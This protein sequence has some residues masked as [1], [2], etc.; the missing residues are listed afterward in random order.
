MRLSLF[1]LATLCTLILGAQRTYINTVDNAVFGSLGIVLPAGPSGHVLFSL[2]QGYLVRYDFCGNQLFAREIDLPGNPELVDLIALSNGDFGLLAA[3]ANIRRDAIVARLDSS[4]NLLWINQYQDANFDQRQFPYSLV[5]ISANRLSYYANLESLS[6]NDTQNLLLWLDAQGA[7]VQARTYSLGR[8]WGRCIAT[9]DSGLLFRTGNRLVKVNE[10]GFVQWAREYLVPNTSSDFSR[11]IALQDGYV[12]FNRLNGSD[13]LVGNKVNLTGQLTHSVRYDAQGGVG[14]PAAI[15]TGSVGLAFTQDFGTGQSSATLVRFGGDSLQIER[16]LSLDGL[17]GIGRS[18]CV[19]NNGKLA[20]AGA[21]TDFP[22]KSFSGITDMDLN[23]GCRRITQG[24]NSTAYAVTDNALA[25]SVAPATFNAVPYIANVLNPSLTIQSQCIPAAV[26][27]L[28]QDTA[29]CA[30]DSL[31]LANVNGYFEAD[32]TWSNGS[33][34]ASIYVDQP[35]TYWV[36]VD[37]GCGQATLRDTI[38]VGL[39]PNEAFTLGPPRY[40]CDGEEVIISGPDCA[41]CGFQWNTGESKRS[42]V[43]RNAG[44]Y[45]LTLQQPNGCEREEEVEV[46]NSG[47]ACDFFMPNAFSPNGDDRNEVIRPIL[48]CVLQDYRFAIYD[49][50]GMLVFDSRSPEYSWNGRIDDRN[51]PSGIFMYSVEYSPLLQGAVQEK[52]YRRGMLVLLR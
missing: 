14:R 34:D 23:S 49:R 29:V 40:I 24:W 39:L 31:R 12:F 7:V 10:L 27:D 38:T 45:R 32:Y 13:F 50:W 19:M 5:E 17:F 18:L 9:A 1:S 43:V 22:S 51:A 11:P 16:R 48:N 3:S 25:V 4:G 30:G 47:C 46:F 35:G 42:I 26:F 36:E 2:D 20:F 8:S 21:V 44:I 15:G 28:G 52:V 6:T 37:L 33:T 41:A